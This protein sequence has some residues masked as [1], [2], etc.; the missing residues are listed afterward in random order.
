MKTSNW[1]TLSLSILI[2]GLAFIPCNSAMLVRGTTYYISPAG[3]DA[4]AGTSPAQAWQT[5]EK[6]NTVALQPGDRVAF[7][8]G[9]AFAGTI[10][11]DENDSGT[12]KVPVI[13]T[14]YGVGR[15]TIKSDNANGLRAVKS[16][17]LRIANIN[18]TA[19]DRNSGD[20]R[21]ISFEN[22][23]HGEIDHVDVRCYQRA[24]VEIRGSQHIRVTYVYA[25][26][27]GYVGITCSGPSDDVYV[28]Y[29][30]AINNPGY[31]ESRGHSGNGIL[32]QSGP[33][34]C[35]IEYCE[36]AYNGWN[37]GNT[38]GWNGPCGIWTWDTDHV[39]IQYCI[40]HDNLSPK[41]DGC[42]FDLD[43]HSRNGIIQYCYSYNNWGAGYL[44]MP[45]G[46]DCPN[47]TCTMRYCISE[48]DGQGTHPNNHHSGIY[49]ADGQIKQDVYIYNNI[50]YNSEGRHC[51]GSYTTTSY[52]H[53][54]NNIFLVRDGGSFFFDQ[55]EPKDPKDY[56]D[57][58]G[59][60][61]WDFGEGDN[62]FGE[63]AGLQAWREKC[64]QEMLNGKP[65]GIYAD[66]MLR[67]PGHGEKLTDPT[68]LP[69]LL[70]YTLRGKS[71]CI[72]AGLSLATLF[73]ITP[74]T[75]DFFGTKFT[76]NMTYAIGAYERPVL[77]TLLYPNDFRQH[78]GDPYNRK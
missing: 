57:Y 35:L 72:N 59:N 51:V 38:R 20:N 18:F 37:M 43:G 62:W 23:Q 40:A 6:I 3:N 24:G 10:T 29:C 77:K 36:A 49:V 63:S 12:D 54:Y 17:F 32:F 68:Q 52:L 71:S 22:V 11:L 73:G 5:I 25:T 13:I 33:K 4:N 48:N 1:L 41:G 47:S 34:N 19:L 50:I 75:Q 74:G 65:V 16:R 70:A 69:K 61:Y 45:I 56:H 42:G 78:T 66:P 31:L 67:D 53:F 8:G 64:G 14:S 7:E 21:G 2:T 28:G 44:I 15:A 9:K 30:R 76:N 26:L 60:L 58:K 39:T 55:S 46:N 27:N